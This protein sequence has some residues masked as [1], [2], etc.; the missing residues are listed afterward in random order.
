MHKSLV[1]KEYNNMI[2]YTQRNQ[3]RTGKGMNEDIDIKI[4]RN[5]L[6]EKDNRI[7]Q[8]SK[9]ALGN[10]ENKA[11]LYMISKIQPNDG[12]DTTYVFNCREFQNLIKWE[13]NAS[14]H[15]M[16]EMLTNLSMLRW[17]IDLDGETEALVQWFN[18][19]HINKKNG[20]IEIKFH[21]DMF[22][23]LFNLQQHLE[24]D[25][26]YYTSYRLQNVVLMKHKYSARLYELLKSYQNNNKKWIFENGTGSKDDI[27][28]KLADYDIGK[29]S[30]DT[31]PIIPVTWSNWA[32]FN[33][34]VLKVAVAE[35]NQYTDIKV[36][37]EG[38]KKDLSM[39]KTRA[40]S[41]IVFY[42]ID[43]TEKELSDTD[44]GIDKEYRDEQIDGE[45]HQYTL[46][47]LFFMGHDWFFNSENKSNAVEAEEG[48]N[49][50]EKK[51]NNHQMLFDVLNSENRKSG[52]DENEVN[53]LYIAAVSDMVVLEV[54]SDRWELCAIDIVLHYY[55]AIEASS[56]ETK[57]TTYL[58]VLDCIKNDY[59]NI[60][61]ETIIRWS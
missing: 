6:V 50:D 33:R 8:N 25:G 1:E 52:F 20:D 2:I 21:E 37:Y 4:I 3:E 38:R 53:Q 59:D 49:D 34:N 51:T 45:S 28:L 17:W 16:K 60:K 47:E 44:V 58:R 32:L 61:R 11:I 56:G 54:R 48:N 41:S 35:I 29:S 23:Y 7:I 12:P 15:K 36:A 19:V 57:K 40:V 10:N 13:K 5:S 31:K 22:P 46:E 30:S 55:D 9:Y 24:E 14:Y 43:K 42:M 27:Q 26:R 18:V 39:K